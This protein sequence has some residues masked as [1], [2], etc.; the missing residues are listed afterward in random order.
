MKPENITKILESG[1]KTSF[2]SLLIL[3]FWLMRYIPVRSSEKKECDADV[4]TDGALI[5]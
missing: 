5:R 4:E 3:M 2:F 1:Q